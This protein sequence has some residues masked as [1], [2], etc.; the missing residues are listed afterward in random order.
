ME[1]ETTLFARLILAKRQIDTV[2]VF[3]AR[4]PVGN[5]YP[6]DTGPIVGPNALALGG[7]NERGFGFWKLQADIEYRPSSLTAPLGTS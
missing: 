3:E 2:S 1:S 4:K 7:E 5:R 6:S